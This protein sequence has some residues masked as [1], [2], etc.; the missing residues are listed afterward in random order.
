M[1]FLHFYV[2]FVAYLLKNS[3]KQY[4]C[5]SHNFLLVV[6]C[7]ETDP[8]NFAKKGLKIKA[9]QKL[10]PKYINKHNMKTRNGML[11]ILLNQKNVST[12]QFPIFKNY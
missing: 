7:S 2:A 10:F 8:L 6:P 11:S 9:M 5:G 3:K 1:L 4:K 12:L